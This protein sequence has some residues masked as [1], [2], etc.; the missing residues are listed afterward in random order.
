MYELPKLERML[1]A[2]DF[3]PLVGQMFQAETD[4]EPVSLLLFKLERK[5]ASSIVQRQPFILFF[6]TPHN[7]LLMDGLYRLRCGRKGPFEVFI[8]PILAPPGDR[9]YQ[10][11]FN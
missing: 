3:D 8:T 5:L 6:R 7:V 2:E 1:T 11:G 10:G 9:I 4:P